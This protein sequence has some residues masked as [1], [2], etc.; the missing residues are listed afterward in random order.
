VTTASALASESSRP[1]GREQVKAAVIAA[2]TGLFDERGPKAT[3]IRDIADRSRVNQGLIH[4]HF[5]SKQGVVAAVLDRLNEQA[6]TTIDHHK[7]EADDEAVSRYLRILARSI[8]DGYPVETLQRRFP[9][10]SGLVDQARAYQMD[11]HAARLAAGHAIALQLGWRLF[12][13]FIRA[14]AGLEDLAP[15]ALHEKA[16]ALSERILRL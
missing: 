1:T 4:R 16:N 9:V 6:V 8:L 5:G 11:E 14:A 7:P 10:V 3:S 13:P 15:A 12:E 2:A